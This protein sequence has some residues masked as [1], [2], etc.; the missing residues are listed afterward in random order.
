M[1]DIAIMIVLGRALLD[2]SKRPDFPF[3]R[4]ANGG[5]TPTPPSSEAGI[6]PRCGIGQKAVLLTNP[7]RWMCVSE[8]K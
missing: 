1:I 3:F 5:V 8:F 2:S 4:P 6:R 7:D